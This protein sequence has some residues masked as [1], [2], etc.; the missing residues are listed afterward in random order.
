[1]SSNDPGWGNR[2]GNGD[3]GGKRTDNQGPPDLEE[4]WQDIN[5]RFFKF[6]G[7][8]TG[9]PR[10]PVNSGGAGAGLPPGQ[11]QRIVLIALFAVFAL[12]MLSGFYTVNTNERAVIS[13]LGKFVRITDSGLNWRLPYPIESHEIVKFTDMRRTQVGGGDKRAMMLT[14]DG[15]LVSVEFAVQYQLKGKTKP[16][17]PYEIGP[18]QYVFN[19]RMSELDGLGEDDER[20]VRQVAE[21]AMREVVATSQMDAVLSY[22]REEIAARAQKLIQGILDSYQSGIQVSRVAM[23]NAAPPAEVQGD[24]KDVIS[25][26]QD[27]VKYKSDAEKYR[28]Q[29][30]PGAQGQASRLRADAEAYR[31]TLIAGAEGQ[32]SRF[33]QLLDEYKKAPQV[34]RERLYLE[35]MQAVM[36]NTSK[37]LIDNKGSNNMLYVPLDKLMQQSAANKGAASTSALPDGVIP[38]VTASPSASAAPSADTDRR[39]DRDRGDR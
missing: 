10:G 33:K 14:Q 39:S 8:K 16:E 22:G 11:R 5:Q 4:I 19:N 38:A 30:V 1:M 21:A 9:G 7:Q 35:T 2:D 36:A 18:M 17:D 12:W 20:F 23:Q 13:R 31:A 3:R 6:F 24:F 34:T 37:V 15:N 25:A 32:S 28:N 27:A 29:V 26:Q